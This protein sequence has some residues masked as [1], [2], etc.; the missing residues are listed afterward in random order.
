MKILKTLIV[1]RKIVNREYSQGEVIHIHLFLFCF[2]VTK[3]LFLCSIYLRRASPKLV[4]DKLLLKKAIQNARNNNNK[5]NAKSLKSAAET[6]ND[7]KKDLIRSI[8]ALGND[9]KP[10]V[11]ELLLQNKKAKTAK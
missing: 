7:T 2:V 1:K 4:R 6:F 3:V 5:T 10:Q 9:L 11:D 8:Q